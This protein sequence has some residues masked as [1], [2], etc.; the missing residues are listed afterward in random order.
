[1]TMEITSILSQNEGTVFVHCVFI[2]YLFVH[3]FCKYRNETNERN[4][5]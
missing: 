5:N 4:S 2:I 3:N 1:M